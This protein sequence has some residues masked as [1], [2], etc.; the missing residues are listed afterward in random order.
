MLRSRPICMLG[1]GRAAPVRLIVRL[2]R[3]RPMPRKL[4]IVAACILAFAA[5]AAAFG[6]GCKFVRNDNL[7]QAALAGDIPGC[8]N[9]L[10][11]GANVNGAGMH[12]MKPIMSAARGGHIE[13]AK[14]PRLQR[15]GRKCSQWQRLRAHVGGQLRK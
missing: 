2:N 8:N 4:P 1:A 6:F 9:L 5:G 13:T 7:N 14:Y 11:K 12:A 3:D 10:S 15:S